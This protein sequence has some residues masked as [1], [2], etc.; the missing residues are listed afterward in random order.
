[1]Q[2][3][4]R[5][6]VQRSVHWRTVR[7]LIAE[8]QDQGVDVIRLA[9]GDPDLPTPANIVETL[10]ESILDPTYHRYPF[11]IQTDIN[12]TIAKWYEN[13]FDV[14]LDP[15]TEV[16]PLAGSLEGIGL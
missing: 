5:I 7:Q 3:A 2:F 4:N 9:S 14:S 11:S 6:N 1:M 13:R 12:E 10:R 8:K 16:T 15:N